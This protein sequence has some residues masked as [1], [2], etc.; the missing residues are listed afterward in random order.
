MLVNNAKILI[1]RGE[2]L[3]SLSVRFSCRGTKLWDRTKLILNLS[4][5]KIGGMNFSEARDSLAKS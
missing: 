5:E 4:A 1:F 2:L 3:A